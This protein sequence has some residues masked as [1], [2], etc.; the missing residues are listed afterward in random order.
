M[1]ELKR[2][3]AMPRYSTPEGLVEKWTAALGQPGAP[4]LR[5]KQAEAIEAL[6]TSHPMCGAI[7]GLSVGSGKTLVAMLAPKV[8]GCEG[9]ALCLTMPRLVDQTQAEFDKWREFYPCEPPL[10]RSY[11]E[12][13]SQA[14]RNL[15]NDIDPRL[16]VCDEAHTLS[17]PRSARTKRFTRFMGDAMG[18]AARGG[19]GCRLVAMSGSFL[20]RKVEELAGLA[21]MALLAGSPLPI[22]NELYSWSPVLDLGGEPTPQQLHGLLPLLRWAGEERRNVQAYRA[23]FQARLLS[24]QG[25]VWSSDGSCDKDLTFGGWRVPSTEKTNEALKTLKELWELPDGTML[26][27]GSE[28]AYAGHMLPYGVYQVPDWDAVG[29]FDEEWVDA[30]LGWARECRAFI[31]YADDPELD[32]P[33]LVAKAAMDRKLNARLMAAWDAWYAVKDR[34]APPSVLRVHDPAMLGNLIAGIKALPEG[35]LVWLSTPELARLLPFPYYGRGSTPPTEGTV[36]V[37]PE[38][39][40]TGWNGQAYH[41]NLVLQPKTSSGG[42]EQ[43]LG[44]THRGGQ[45]QD[46]HVDI[47]L[48]SNF[49]VANTRKALDNTETR[50]SLV[51]Q[52]AKLSRLDF[53]KLFKTGY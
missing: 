48:Q 5:P 53:P 45:T 31:E 40:G 39:H 52:A 26:V 2:I 17:N 36:L 18:R 6:A 10:V 7:L 11:T 16:I 29:G 28:V 15:L 19:E 30:R 49:Q 41:L 20:S 44:R 3:L 8:L 42:W 34:P 12:L 22:G 35:T 38:V 23:A 9:R 51:G 37:S 21:G 33:G 13:S 14:G 4:A 27:S 32:S 46:V 47:S 1:S 24:T 50:T 43:L 25:V